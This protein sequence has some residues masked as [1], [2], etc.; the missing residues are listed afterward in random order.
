MKARR[1]FS[2]AIYASIIKRQGGKCACGCSEPLGTD[3]RAIQYDHVLPLYLDGKDEPENLRAL[4]T[5]HHLLKTVREH[6]ARAKMNR[7]AD[8]DGL[9]LPKLSARD[10][11]LARM[12]ERTSQ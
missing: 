1:R 3:P 7:I 10:K 12:L 8:R 11:A 2:P 4:K 6:K 9:K 5:R